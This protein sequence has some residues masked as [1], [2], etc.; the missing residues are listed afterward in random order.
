MK[1]TLL[2]GII[3]FLI[4]TGST[5]SQSSLTYSSDSVIAQKCDNQFSVAGIIKVYNNTNNQVTLNWIMTQSAFPTAGWTA[6][7]IDPIQFPPNTYAGSSYVDAN[8]ST[9]I[10]FHIVPDTMTPGDTAIFQ[11]IIY[12]ELDSISTATYLTALVYCPQAL[13]ITENNQSSSIFISPNPFKTQAI[14]LFHNPNTEK[15]FLMI[16]NSTLQIVK[17]ISLEN[18]NVMIERNNFNS[19]LYFWQLWDKQKIIDYGKL[20]IE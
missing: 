4:C 2:I 11:I 5:V 8:D 13:Y 15:H 1:K 18:E 17:R 10:L 16:Y 7:I 3:L 14:V 12:D 19:G 20:I 9:D 6:L